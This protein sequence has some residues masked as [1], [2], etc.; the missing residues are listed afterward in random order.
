MRQK[1][2]QHFLRDA[3]LLLRIAGALGETRDA[4]VIEI[5]PGHGELTVHLL[6]LNIKKLIAIERDPSLAATLKTRYANDPRL[7]VVEGNALSLLASLVRGE[8]EYLIVGNIPYYITGFLLRTIG[9]LKKKPRRTLLLVQ[10]EV[11]ERITA[12]PPKMNLLAAIL[13]SW[14]KPELLEIVPRESFS[15]PPEVQSA[16]LRLDSCPAIPE[17]ELDAYAKTA[18]GIFAQPRKTILNNLLAATG[19]SAENTTLLLLLEECGVSPSERAQNLSV[20]QIHAIS[21]A[22]RRR[23]VVE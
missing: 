22:I 14:A 4:T 18:R 11:A 9:G 3:S 16:L 1:L 15:P 13:R 23:K 19:C 6:A 10:R 17:S 7:E 12:E 8:E 20:E 2:G 21:T 5:G